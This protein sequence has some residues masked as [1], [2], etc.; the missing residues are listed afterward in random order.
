MKVLDPKGWK[1]AI[2]YA[3]GIAACGTQIFVGGQIGWNGQQIFESEELVDQVRQTLENILAVLAEADA[4]PEHIAHMTWF[5][6]DKQDY[7][8]KRREIGAVYRDL[9]GRH[10]PAMTLVQVADLLEDQAKVEIEV[11]AVIPNNG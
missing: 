2:G 8:A 4:G 6:V 9:I 11:T 1:Q 10:F 3:N 5:V 7:L